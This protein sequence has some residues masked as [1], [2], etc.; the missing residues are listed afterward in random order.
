MSQN[1]SWRTAVLYLWASADMNTWAPM[2][3]NE[4]AG[5]LERHQQEPVR[6]IKDSVQDLQGQLASFSHQRSPGHRVTLSFL[7]M[8]LE[9][10][11]DAHFRAS[12]RRCCSTEKGGSVQKSRSNKTVLLVCLALIALSASAACTGI[13]LRGQ[14][15]QGN[16]GNG[17][18]EIEVVLWA[19]VSDLA[20]KFFSGQM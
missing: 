19:D 3:D 14:F 20:L 13:Y 16:S 8:N 10:S 1:G 15:Q 12:N 4:I 7:L 6:G 17:S 9:L 5:S 11:L 18:A 2:A